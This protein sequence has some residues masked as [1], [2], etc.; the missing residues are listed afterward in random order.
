MSAKRIGLLSVLGG[1]ALAGCQ[2]QPTVPEAPVEQALAPMEAPVTPVGFTRAVI[3]DG[4]AVTQTFVS[5]DAGGGSW[6]DSRGCAWSTEDGFAPTSQWKSCPPHADGTQTV[7]TTDGGAWPLQVGS[8]WS[9]NYTGENTNGGSWSGV[10]KCNVVG[11]ARITVPAGDFDSYKVECNQSSSNRTYYW[12]PSAKGGLV[13]YENYN[14]NSG[15]RVAWDLV[16][17]S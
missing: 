5:D 15:R 13:R 2:S 7:T 11:T 17:T 6:K 8:R 3:R 12:S 9:Y 16:S 14:H 10:R 4:E 1:L